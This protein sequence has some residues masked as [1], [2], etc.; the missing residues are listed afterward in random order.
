MTQIKSSNLKVLLVEDCPTDAM[1]VTTIMIEHGVEV[2]CVC[3][4]AEALRAIVANKYDLLVLDFVLPDTTAD[5]LVKEFKAKRVRTPFVM[6]SGTGS[7]ED[8]VAMMKLGAMD[9]IPKKA[10]Y[11]TALASV[12]L[13][14]VYSR[15]VKTRKN[16]ASLILTSLS[17]LLTILA[18]W[19]AWNYRDQMA[20]EHHRLQIV[21]DMVSAA[22]HSMVVLD[23]QG[24]I[25]EWSDSMEALV[26]WTWDDVKG[27]TP[28]FLMAEIYRGRHQANYDVALQKPGQQALAAI[29]C[30][31]YKKDG[32]LI[33]V[34]ISVV[35][36]QNHHG[37]YAIAL[38][39]D[40]MKI[41]RVNLAPKPD[42]HAPHDPHPD[43]NMLRLF[44]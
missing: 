5:K 26:G 27:S 1:I 41:V 40:P 31:V 37:K 32:T 28:E 18:F 12:L 21:S 6:V 44:K 11:R 20:I 29:D 35:T 13:R 7:E 23:P 25:C 14:H 2:E 38:F 36:F 30:W 42:E 17:C 24:R 8:A 15:K 43:Q 3:T 39:S 16:A 10:D 19:R 22:G 33:P 34:H 9:Y 4:G